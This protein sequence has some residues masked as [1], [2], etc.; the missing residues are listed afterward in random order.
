MVRVFHLLTNPDTTF[1]V[2]LDPAEQLRR[3]LLRDLRQQI[4]ACLSRVPAEI[5]TVEDA[6]LEV[7]SG[8]VSGVMMVEM[9]RVRNQD[10]ESALSLTKDGDGSWCEQPAPEVTVTGGKARSTAVGDM[11]VHEDGVYVVSPEGLIRCRF[12]FVDMV[13]AR[14][15][16]KRAPPQEVRVKRPRTPKVAQAAQVAQASRGIGSSL[17]SAPVVPLGTA[18]ATAAATPKGQPA[19]PANPPA[20]HQPQADRVFD[21]WFEGQ[22]ATVPDMLIELEAI[23][24]WRVG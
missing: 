2:Q 22:R 21:R 7:F 3:D 23:R 9:A 6:I 10:P 4:E 8:Q 19:K 18:R 24:G 13:F 17:A 15:M 14:I 11:L 16:A 12:S 1:R 20:R 5:K